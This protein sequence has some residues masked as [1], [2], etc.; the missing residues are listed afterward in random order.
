MPL[1]NKEPYITPEMLNG[2]LVYHDNNYVR[3]YRCGKVGILHMID[4]TMA[5]IKTFITTVAATEPAIEGLHEGVVRIN[6]T[7]TGRYF[8]HMYLSY[9][10]S[11]YYT[12]TIGY[13]SGNGYPFSG[14]S[15]IDLDNPPSNID[16]LTGTIIIPLK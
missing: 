13:Y 9:T 5:Q 12:Y 11:G 3:Y 2:N 15:T 8:G 14:W 6:N 4:A 16:S 7:G 10:S 1:I